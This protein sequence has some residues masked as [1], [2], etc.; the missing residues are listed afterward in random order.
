MLLAPYSLPPEASMSNIFRHKPLAPDELVGR[1]DPANGRVYETRFGP[2]KLVGRVD[3][4]S[5]KVY[6]ARLGP[7]EYLGRVDLTDGKTYRSRLGPDEYVGRVHD[8]GKL[9]RH[10][11]LGPDDY[12]GKV[13]DMRTVAEG[14][15]ALLL[16]LLEDGEAEEGEPPADAP[17][18]D[19]G[20]G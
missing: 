1:V 18:E 8:D 6:H 3:L 14:G 9:Y 10:V 15:A 2:D 13:T 16:F 4:D 17:K 11:A 20:A 19:Q 12:L 7:D 5:G